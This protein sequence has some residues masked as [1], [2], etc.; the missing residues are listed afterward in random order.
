MI[1]LGSFS[2]ILRFLFWFRLFWGLKCLVYRV[3]FLFLFFKIEV[4]EK[5]VVKRVFTLEFLDFR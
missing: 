5:G 1:C 3:K 2:Y 4:F